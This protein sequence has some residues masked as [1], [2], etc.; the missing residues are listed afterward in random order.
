MPRIVA[1]FQPVSY[2]PS[3][4]PGVG[5]ERTSEISREQYLCAAPALPRMGLKR[6]PESIES[7]SLLKYR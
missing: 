4:L 3:T 7:M 2:L 6:K 5:V 1:G